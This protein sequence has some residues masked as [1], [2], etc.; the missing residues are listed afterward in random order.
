MEIAEML[1][2]REPKFDGDVEVKIIDNGFMVAHYSPAEN[3]TKILY[4]GNSGDLAEYLD[5]LTAFYKQ[6][7]SQAWGESF[8]PGKEN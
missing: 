3:R 7:I 2:G 8:V 4:F 6:E 1:A 5:S